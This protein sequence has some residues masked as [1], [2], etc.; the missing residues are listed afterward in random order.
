MAGHNVVTSGEIKA[1]PLGLPAPRERRL[2]LRPS[3]WGYTGVCTW[4]QTHSKLEL[5]GQLQ[6]ACEVGLAVSHTPCGL[7]GLNTPASQDTGA[8]HSCWYLAPR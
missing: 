6:L 4:G 3:L 7:A 1:K 5:W 2:P 8:V